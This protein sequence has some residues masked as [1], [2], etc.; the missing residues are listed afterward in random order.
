MGASVDG[1]GGE[2]RRDLHDIDGRIVKVVLQTWTLSLRGF[3]EL[4][5]Y[6]RYP[7]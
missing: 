2:R 6:M 1:D 7:A 3:D 4:F 5:F